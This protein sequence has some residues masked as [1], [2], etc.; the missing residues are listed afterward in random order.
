[1][2]NPAFSQWL[3]A[4]AQALDQ[5]HCDPQQVLARLAEAQVL[6]IGIPPG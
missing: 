5:G 1:M 2:L 4:E 6:R 3:D